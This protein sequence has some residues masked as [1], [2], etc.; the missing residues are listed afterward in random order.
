MTDRKKH[1][2]KTAA[3]CVLYPVILAVCLAAFFLL[4]VPK[5]PATYVALGFTVL[6]WI[7]TFFF[8]VKNTKHADTARKAF[9]AA[10]VIRMGRIYLVVQLI[11]GV[12][13]CTVDGFVHLSVWISAA[14]CAL[15]F[16][17]S[18]SAMIASGV[19]KKAIAPMETETEVKIRAVTEFKIDIFSVL[20]A[21]RSEELRRDLEKLAD[22]FKYSDPVSSPETVE[23]EKKIT[24]EIADLAKVVE[25]DKREK[26][27]EHIRTVRGLLSER[28]RICKA[29]KRT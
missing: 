16:V 7:I 10:P 18:I 1:I 20:D 3:Y 8:T 14:V 29:Y 21:C 12:V 15:W 4:P 24:A 17:A 5:T 13:L 25:A 26:A 2:K 6:S 9:Y 28:N 22:D 23:I 11:I 27:K 19:T